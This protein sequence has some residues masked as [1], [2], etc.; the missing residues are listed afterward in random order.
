MLIR[1]STGG[2]WWTL[3]GPETSGI[4]TGAAKFQP[5]QNMTWSHG[6]PRIPG[7]VLHDAKNAGK[8]GKVSKVLTLCEFRIARRPFAFQ[9]IFGVLAPGRRKSAAAGKFRT[10]VKAVLLSLGR[11]LTGIR[12]ANHHKLPDHIPSTLCYPDLHH[13]L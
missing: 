2:I 10:G 12:P 11:K 3:P 9:R 8:Y 7:S 13:S 1:K 6:H 4:R 5:P